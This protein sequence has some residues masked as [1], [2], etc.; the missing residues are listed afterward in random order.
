MIINA[1]W[2]GR[3]RKL[4]LNRKYKFIVVWLPDICESLYSGVIP[5]S[6]N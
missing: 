1:A 5:K 6:A 2:V 3:K 4:N